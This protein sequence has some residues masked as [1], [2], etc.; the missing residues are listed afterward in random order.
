MSNHQKKKKKSTMQ[1]TITISFFI[2]HIKSP[3]AC[4]HAFI[5][6][7]EYEQKKDFECCLGLSGCCPSPTPQKGIYSTRSGPQGDVSGIGKKSSTSFN[8]CTSRQAVTR[9]PGKVQIKVCDRSLKRQILFHWKR[10]VKAS[11]R[12]LF[13]SEVL[14]QV[15]DIS[16]GPVNIPQ[17]RTQ[18]RALRTLRGA[19]VKQSAWYLSLRPQPLFLRRTKLADGGTADAA[20]LPIEL[21]LQC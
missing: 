14:I 4:Y 5:L 16:L 21:P 15:K 8:S 20:R 10:Q 9:A 18:T 11:W 19:G 17:L 1:I 12:R 6:D 13:L 2:C 3:H 7:P